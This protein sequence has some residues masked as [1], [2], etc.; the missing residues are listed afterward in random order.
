M[1]RENVYFSPLSLDLSSLT[2]F[3]VGWRLFLPSDFV[4]LFT[5][6]FGAKPSQAWNN[7]NDS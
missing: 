5:L 6:G 1:L 3:T 7:H 2:L 4:Y